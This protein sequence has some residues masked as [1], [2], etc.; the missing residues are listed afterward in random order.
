[1]I[2]ALYFV[3]RNDV[4][5]QLNQAPQQ[6]GTKHPKLVDKHSVIITDRRVFRII[7]EYIIIPSFWPSLEKG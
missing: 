7:L 5:Q 2:K 4:K 1:M 6:N 3:N